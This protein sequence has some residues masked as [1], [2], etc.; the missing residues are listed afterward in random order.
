MET[1]LLLDNIDE[2]HNKAQFALTWKGFSLKS[3]RQNGYISIDSDNDF[4]VIEKDK[5]RIKIGYLGSEINGEIKNTHYGIRISNE[6]ENVVM[7]TDSKGQLWLE[8]GL[9]IGE[10]NTANVHIGRFEPDEEIYKVIQAGKSNTDTPFIVYENGKVVANYIEVN[11]GKIGTLDISQV[12]K[13]SY[14]VRITSDKGISMLEGTKVT[15]TATLLKN[16]Q[17]Y[18]PEDDE[19]LLYS[20]YKDN[21]QISGANINT[22]T[23]EDID[24]GNLGYSA[25]RCEITISKEDGE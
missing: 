6:D 12:E 13:Q 21:E 11:G 16:G 9:Y 15:L 23:I 14:E 7:Q 25:Y 17:T 3:N 4:R 2:I 19:I 5:E 1:M 8:D 22:L 24:F 10:G 20:W 18:T